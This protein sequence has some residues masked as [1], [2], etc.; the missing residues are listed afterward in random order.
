MNIRKLYQFLK[1]RNS[2]EIISA[3]L[4]VK[5]EPPVVGN[6]EAEFMSDFTQ[7]E[8]ENYIHNEVHGWGPFY[9]KLRNKVWN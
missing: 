6:Q 7:E 9:K 3:A 2:D 8:Y 4:N 1:L 5:E